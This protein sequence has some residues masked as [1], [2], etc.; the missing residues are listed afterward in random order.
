MPRDIRRNS[1]QDE[2]EGISVVRRFARIAVG[3]LIEREAFGVKQGLQQGKMV[4][5]IR[6]LRCE[7]NLIGLIGELD[8]SAVRHGSEGTRNL[9][10]ES[11]GRVSVHRPRKAQCDAI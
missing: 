2:R 4:S 11:T 7:S 10:C 6:R 1:I 5:A 9:Q 3:I 8:Q